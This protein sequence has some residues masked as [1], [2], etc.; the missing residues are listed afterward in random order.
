MFKY[1]SYLL[2]FVI[3]FTFDPAISVAQ[4]DPDDDRY[5]TAW[6]SL[7]FR[8][9]GPAFTSGRIADFAVNPDDISE[10][11][12]ATASG[13]VWKTTNRGVSLTPVFD[14]QGSYSIGVVEMDPN[15]HN[16]VWVGTGE[17]NN[18]RSVAYGDGVYKTIDGGKSWSHMG[19]KDSEHIGM[20]AIDPRDSDVVY[21]AATGPLWSAGGDR[22]LYKTTDGGENWEKILDISEH[23]GIHEVHLDPRDPDLVYAVAHQRRRRV[24]TYISGG[25]ESAV[26]KSTDAGQNF[27]KIMKGM[28]GGDIGRIGLDISPANPDVVYAVV[29]AQ[30]GRSGF[31]RSTDRGESWEKRSSYSGSGNYYNEVIADP[32]DPDLVYVMNTY[33]GVSED[34][35]KNFNNVGE[36]NKHIDNHALWINPDNTNHLLNGN[37]GGVYE[38][39]D[40]GKTWRFYTNLPVTQFYKVAVDNDYP[41]YNIYGGTQDNFTFGGPARTTETT[42]I[43]NRQWVV[44]VLGDGFEPHV[45]PTNPD[46]VYSQSQYGNLRR[47][48]RQ[49][50]EI[51]NIVPQPPAGDYS[52][53]WNW[54]SPFFVSVHDNKR[55]YFASDRVHRS[56]DRGQSWTEVSGDLTRQIDRNQLK[57]MDKVWSM[58]AVAKN[59]S[60]TQYGN[61][62]ALAE[63][64]LNEDV[65]FAGTD[66][67]LI[68]VTT[69]GGENWRRTD[70]FPTVPEMTYVNEIVASVHDPNVVYAAFNNHK[71]GDFK[72]YLLKSMDLGRSW[73]PITNN[74]PERGSI[75]AIAE[76]PVEAGLLFIGTEFSMF[77]SIDGGNYWEEFNRGLP[78]VAVRDIN[79]QER[80]KDLALA[81]FGRGFYIMDDYS[82]LREF[83]QEVHD[84][85]AHLFSVR[86]AFQ[87]QP[88]SPI[89]ASNTISWLGPK[90]FQG[91][92]YYLGENPEFGA[93]FTYYLKDGYKTLEDQRKDEEK[94]KRDD[95]ENVFYPSYEQM[96]AEAE[97]E[98]PLLIFTIR[99]TDGEVVDEIRS[100]PRK[101]INRIYWDLT[102][103]AVQEIDTDL[104]DPSENLE[105]GIMVLPG[106][107]TVQLSK[108]INGEVTVLTEPVSFNV[109]SLDNRTLPA[110]DPEAM[111]AFHKELMQLSKSANSA[112]NAWNEINERLQYY[113]GAARI[114]ESE[115]LEKM[116]SDLEDK[117]EEI[118]TTM[119]GDRIKSRLEIDQ[120]P[121]LN[122]RINTAIGAGISAG[123]DP[124][125][126][127][128]MVKNIAEQ[129]LRPV[130]ASLKK[131]IAEDIPA[132]DAL[133]DELNA[134]WTPGRIVD[135]D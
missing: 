16:V 28:P 130:I 47:F 114:T 9:I 17:N 109:K 25:P 124:T 33:A 11:Y 55:L 103:P 59:A 135:L 53:N 30:Q 22:G 106:E 110:Q 38:S 96:K 70:N 127:S 48:D 91:E 133:L 50:G 64:P 61:I 105:S 7:E 126:T 6:N 80:E 52:Y 46:I 120:A 123:S 121:S 97:E 119:F 82:A 76:D 86:D 77:A 37:D 4:D 93:A 132:F 122:S 79:I 8:S 131:I 40:R 58:D 24:F 115:E 34:G 88:F 107:Y 18:Q 85:E 2:A 72:P 10:F 101:G 15:N 128:K 63:S 118:Q 102:Y 98:A 35:G 14:S 67:G 75:Y 104:A 42:G 41:F 66:D 21:V 23:T 54:D 12:V 108:H 100:S 5:N 111:L 89:A 29:E 45:D 39:Y 112:R 87:Y 57:V 19:L 71:N 116:I 51:Q 125:E 44:T 90:G 78:T 94:E 60:T 62:V 69:D 129:E 27:R 99:D 134:P 92:D 74:L 65:L 43:T 83:S 68:H 56:D 32:V 36:L 113:K 84:K 3:Y 117:M 31:Y 26:Y 81:T 1:L 73:R 13:G 20:I 95:G 49:S